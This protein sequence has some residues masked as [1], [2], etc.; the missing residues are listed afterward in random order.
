[1]AILRTLSRRR[2]GQQFDKTSLCRNLALDRGLKNPS[3]QLTHEEHFPRTAMAF[4]YL[5]R[6]PNLGPALSAGSAAAQSQPCTGAAKLTQR[7]RALNKTEMQLFMQGASA[8]CSWFVEWA[9][10]RIWISSGVWTV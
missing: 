8:I 3:A 4:P 5:G 2:V 9:Q 7:Y 10:N 6:E 1:M